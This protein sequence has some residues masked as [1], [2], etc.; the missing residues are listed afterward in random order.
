M[1]IRFSFGLWNK[2]FPG[3]LGIRN[4]LRAVQQ[5]ARGPSRSF[6]EVALATPTMQ[7]VQES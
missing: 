2:A 7:A 3:Y 5:D 4:A 1:P 6:A